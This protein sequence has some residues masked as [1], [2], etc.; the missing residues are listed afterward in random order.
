MGTDEEDGRMMSQYE[1]DT[2]PSFSV[3]LKGKNL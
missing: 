3:E 1:R 2:D